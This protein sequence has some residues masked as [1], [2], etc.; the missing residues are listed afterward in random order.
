MSLPTDI[1][2]S[3]CAERGEYPDEV[4]MAACREVNTGRTNR[5]NPN[6]ETR[7]LLLI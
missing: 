7:L 3:N 4:W 6:L 2:S 1:R 5:V